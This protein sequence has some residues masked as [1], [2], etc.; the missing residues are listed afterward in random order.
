MKEATLFKRLRRSKFHPSAIEVFLQEKRSKGSAKEKFFA[1]RLKMEIVYGN[2]SDVSLTEI[3]GKLNEVLSEYSTSHKDFGEYDCS[4]LGTSIK[5]FKDSNWPFVNINGDFTQTKRGR[6]FHDATSE[7]AL[8]ETLSLS[9]VIELSAALDIFGLGSASTDQHDRQE[10]DRRFDDLVKHIKDCSKGGKMPGD[11]IMGS[12]KT[13]CC[14]VAR[15]E[16]IE[17]LLAYEGGPARLMNYLG[18]PGTR[19]DKDILPVLL[20][21][22]TADLKKK[23]YKP[24]FFDSNVDF[25][26][27]FLSA[28]KSK[29]ESWGKT[30][31]LPD[32]GEGLHEAVVKRTE[33]P[34]NFNPDKHL[35][36]L[37][38]VEEDRHD[39]TD[40]QMEN[41]VNLKRKEIAKRWKR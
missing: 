17:R 27:Y 11:W 19:F 13:H 28:P 25:G 37:G 24:T 14:F 7:I 23:L 34:P 22:D 36:P 12:A 10:Q 15:T 38:R 6:A 21:F 8:A 20:T 9:F 40:S 3:F 18:F 41:F 33:V 5:E 30:L 29:S 35:K 2:M 1:L 31:R 4:L 16:D 26:S 39:P 32:L